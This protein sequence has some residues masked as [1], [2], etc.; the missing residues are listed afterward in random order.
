VTGLEH[1]QHC[2]GRIPVGEVT[3]TAN[4]LIHGHT[5]FAQWNLTQRSIQFKEDQLLL[6]LPS[7]KTDPFRKGVTITLSA[8]NE[9]RLR[10]LT[11][12]HGVVPE[13][14]RAVQGACVQAVTLDGS[15]L[16]CD[17][18]DVGR[19]DDLQLLLNRQARS[20]LG[21]LPTTPRGAL[22]RES[23]LTPA[24]V[25]L[26]SRQQQFEARLAN[27]CSSKL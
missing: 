6:P 26:D 8:F 17:T 11:K 27:A 14:V 25:M 5:E 23:G 13:S 10:T 21:T 22:M 3:W 4:D 18:S 2:T 16:W 7:S 9:A 24:P 15:E 1:L 12:T 19:R 20:I